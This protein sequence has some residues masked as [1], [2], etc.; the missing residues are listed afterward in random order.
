MIHVLAA[1]ERNLKN[2]ALGK[3]FMIKGED[4][5]PS[6]TATLKTVVD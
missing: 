3:E 1:A 5:F 2:A 4:M 6:T